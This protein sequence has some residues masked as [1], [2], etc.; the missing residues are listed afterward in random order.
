MRLLI[1]EDEEQMLSALTR[2]FKQ[3]GYAVDGSED[4]ALGLMLAQTNDYDVLILDLNL[5]GMDGLEVLRQIR[6]I[7]QEQKILVLS[8]RSSFDERIVGLDCG[9]NDYLVKP[10]D[11][12]ELA[13]RVRNLLRR[14]FIQNPTLLEFYGLTL[15]TR[16]HS[17]ITASGGNIS[18]PHKEYAILEYLLLNRGR[19]VSAEELIE[20]I[21]QEEDGLFSNAIKVHISILRKKL[22]ATGAPTAIITIR[23]AGYLIK[24]EENRG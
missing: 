6:R 19:P 5:P 23:G 21:W 10:F 14:N 12:G 1:I 16:Q 18:L 8:A 15:N 20:H 11:F 22:A 24:E 2:G 7:N 17:L 3:L 4:G 9:A 13:A